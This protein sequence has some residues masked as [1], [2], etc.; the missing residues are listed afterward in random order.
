M[1]QEEKIEVMLE[2]IFKSLEDISK[3]VD[4]GRGGGGEDLAEL[5]QRFDTLITKL[6]N[7]TMP[8][9]GRGL[10]SLDQKL[11]VLIE[12][13]AYHQ[14]SESGGVKHHHYLWF[15]PDIKEWLG[16]VRSSGVAWVLGTFLLL[17]IGINYLMGRDY[18]KYQESDLKY[19]YIKLSGNLDYI[20]DLDSAWQIDSLREARIKYVM[21]EEAI[22]QAEV[23]NHRKKMELRRQLDS[24]EQNALE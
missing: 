8:I 14:P 11:N 16:M 2:E 18:L 24:L 1:K 10:S 13:S 21:E 22:L 17:S 12:R 15:F 19:Q 5:K 4:A 20:H 23:Q 7:V 3:K 9:T 6:G